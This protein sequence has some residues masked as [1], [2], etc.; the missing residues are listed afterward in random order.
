MTNEYPLVHAETIE[1]KIFV[2]RGQRVMIDRDIADLYQV[3]TKYLNRQ[4]KR[5]H[6]RFPPEFMFQLTSAEKDQLVTNWHRFVSLKHSTTRPYAFTE[7]G[8][9]MLSSVLN[10][11][12]AIHVNI[13]IIKTFIRLREIAFTSRELSTKLTEL[14]L[15]YDAQFRLVFQA[16]RNLMQLPEKPKKPI[17]FQVKERREV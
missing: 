12:R 2:I 15:K 1:Q 4:V 13:Q 3:E 5:N 6:E 9:A 7:H 14:E 8:I 10:S 17:G 16:I 11:R